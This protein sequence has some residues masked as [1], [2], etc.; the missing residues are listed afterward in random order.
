M[1]AHNS[2]VGADQG[3]RAPSGDQES[4]RDSVHEDSAS[5]AIAAGQRPRQSFR[6][7][8]GPDALRGLFGVARFSPL[9][10]ATWTQTPG[11][12]RRRRRATAPQRSRLWAAAR[13]SP[14]RRRCRCNSALR[15]ILHQDQ[16]GVFPYGYPAAY[17][18]NIHHQ[19]ILILRNEP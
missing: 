12:A 2:V 4:V 16:K 8:Q 6:H 10:L 19:Y 13:G 18:P 9:P 11:Q 5:A 14:T 7:P 15:T 17:V 3:F 1:G